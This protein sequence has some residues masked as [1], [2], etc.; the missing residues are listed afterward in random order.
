MESFRT[1]P[2]LSPTQSIEGDKYEFLDD[3]ER[4]HRMAKDA[5]GVDVV[6]ERPTLKRHQEEPIDLT[7]EDDDEKYPATESQIERDYF[8]FLAGKL[9]K[10]E[11]SEKEYFKMG[12]EF[13]DYV[14]DL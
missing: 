2:S 14:N 4:V 6:W 5:E 8:E 13:Y 10:G 9:K 7:N 3:A 1:P 12:A 11:I